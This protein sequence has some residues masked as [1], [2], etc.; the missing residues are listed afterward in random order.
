MSKLGRATAECLWAECNL[1]P[2]D[3]AEFK[4]LTQGLAWDGGAD[5][6]WVRLEKRVRRTDKKLADLLSARIAADEAITFYCRRRTE[7][8]VK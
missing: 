2:L 7:R 8:R 6:A 5:P 4:R 1:E 3:Q